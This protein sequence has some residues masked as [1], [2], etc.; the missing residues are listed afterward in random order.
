MIF[1]V[2]LWNSL[3]LL[4]MIAGRKRQKTTQHAVTHS[5]KEG[6]RQFRDIQLFLGFL[7]NVCSLHKEKVKTNTF[8]AAGGAG[9]AA[10][11]AGRGSTAATAGCAASVLNQRLTHGSPARSAGSSTCCNTHTYT[12][13]PHT[14]TRPRLLRWARA[15]PGRRVWAC[16]RRRC[17]PGWRARWRGRCGWAGA[18]PVLSMPPTGPASRALRS[19]TTIVFFLFWIESLIP[20]SHTEPYNL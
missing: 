8:L 17:R 1:L 12:R 7:K 18:R 5:V 16:R 20:V 3:T 10:Q 9:G 14:H 13:T 19:V 15:L 4:I 6:R 11:S 2:G